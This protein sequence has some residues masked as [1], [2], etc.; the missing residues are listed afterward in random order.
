M[1]QQGKE[2]DDEKDGEVK[3]LLILY[4]KIT[5]IFSFQPIIFLSVLPFLVSHPTALIKVSLKIFFP[6]FLSSYV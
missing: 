4:F 6:K 2:E 1:K 3:I 5:G